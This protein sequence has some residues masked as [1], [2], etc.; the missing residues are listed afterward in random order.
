MR[1]CDDTEVEAAQANYSVAKATRDGA[2]CLTTDPC[3]LR[4]VDVPDRS[5]VAIETVACAARRP[6]PG[7]GGPVDP[8]RPCSV[9]PTVVENT[10][11]PDT[12]TAP[13]LRAAVVLVVSVDLSG[14][15]AMDQ[16]LDRIGVVSGASVYPLV[17]TSCW[18]PATRVT[19]GSL[20]TMAVP[21][22]AL[23]AAAQSFARLVTNRDNSG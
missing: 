12:F 8:L 2:P 16:D 22:E 20:T 19:C 14:V 23:S 5:S 3:L 13:F 21:E 1:A 9:A 10:E 18:P 17:W 15:A 4:G 11:V 6:N 7:R